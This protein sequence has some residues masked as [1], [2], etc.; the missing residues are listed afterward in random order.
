MQT[1]LSSR[2][3]LAILFLLVA[4][5]SPAAAQL[6]PTT[7]WR[8]KVDPVVQ[9]RASKAGQTRVIIRAADS[10]L[11]FALPVVVRAAAGTVGRTLGIIGGIVATIPNTA[12]PVIAGNSL[13]GHI[14]SDR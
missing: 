10:Q 12:I 6:L 11:Q 14:S 7:Q 4:V 5:A 8:A 2:R 1:R 9:A 13:V 3:I